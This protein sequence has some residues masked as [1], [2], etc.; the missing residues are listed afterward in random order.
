MPLPAAGGCPQSLAFLGLETPNNLAFT[1][2]SI[3][4]TNLLQCGL[5]LTDYIY[6]K[7]ISKEGHIHRHLG[8]R[9]PLICFGDTIQPTVGFLT[10]RLLLYLLVYTPSEG[11]QN[12]QHPPFFPTQTHNLAWRWMAWGKAEHRVCWK[13]LSEKIWQVS[14]LVISGRDGTSRVPRWKHPYMK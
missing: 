12:T 2:N 3:S 5:V 14:V 11:T 8:L 7:P 9:L 13:S 6:K 10:L 4:R 1:I